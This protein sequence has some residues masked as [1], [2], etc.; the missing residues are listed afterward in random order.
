MEFITR[1]RHRRGAGRPVRRRACDGAGQ[2]VRQWQAADGGHRLRPGGGYDLWGRTVARHM[3]KHL[4][5]NPNGVPQ[6]MPARAATTPPTTSTISRPRTARSSASSRAT[7]PWA[8]HRPEGPRFDPLKISWIGTPAKETNVCIA[9]NTAKVKKV[10]DI[11]TTELIVGDTGV[12]TGTHAYPKALS[13]ILGM[14]FR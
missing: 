2:P 11:Y 1:S 6:N 8:A 4:P 5:G 7:R 14:K 9:Y 13:A 3:G 12:G 10:E